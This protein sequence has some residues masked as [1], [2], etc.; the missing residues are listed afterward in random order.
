MKRWLFIAMPLLATACTSS[1]VESGLLV[2]L[3]FDPGLA[4]KCVQ[5][6]ARVG[7]TERRSGAIELTGFTTAPV[8]VARGDFPDVVTLQ[9]L[10]FSDPGCRTLTTPAE[11][12]LPAEGRFVKNVVATPVAL[13]VRREVGSGEVCTN[14]LDDDGDQQIDCADDDCNRKP[15][16]LGNACVVDQLCNN[17]A[18]GGGTLKM[19]VS[20]PSACF[21]PSGNCEAPAGECKYTPRALATCDDTDPCTT[22]DQC[23]LVGQ[24][25]GSPKPCN[26]PPSQCF[27]PTGTCSVDG[28]C[29]Y[30]LAEG[31]VCNDG[32]SCTI[33]DR[34]AADAGCSG[35]Q[36]V[37]G[38]RECAV[39]ASGCDGDG[40]CRYAPTDAGLACTGGVCN[41]GGNCIESFPYV[42]SN[43]TE[44]QIP[45]LP[46]GPTELSC[47]QTIIDTSTFPPTVTNWCGASAPDFGSAVINQADEQPLML[48]S[49]RSL[50]VFGGSSLTLKGTRNPVLVVT[51]DAQLLGSV[52]TESGSRSCATGGGKSGAAELS[53]G[54]GGGGGFGTVG[55]AGGKGIT[56]AAGGEGGGVNGEPT[57]VPLRGGCPGGRGGDN[58]TASALGGGS[59]QI[60]VGGTLTVSGTVNAPGKGGAG[61]NGVTLGPAVAGNG[62]GSGGAVL[63]EAESIVFNNAARLTANGGGGGQAGDIAGGNG[64]SG[65]SGTTSLLV[66]RGGTTGGAGGPGGDGAVRSVAA[67]AGSDSGAGGGG[68]GVIRVNTLTGCTVDPS[69]ILSPAPTSRQA[70]SGC[71]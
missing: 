46:A 34:C 51:G 12:S 18:C 5:L 16:S 53:N 66:A 59:L 27:G 63:L 38:T 1:D 4:S 35:V 41:G 57:L 32:Q 9:A 71:L 68:V 48:L 13:R 40:G 2:T 61:G 65:Q 29:Q 30:A 58:S 14:G 62:G 26:T 70:G 44:A 11:T 21:T 39:F 50:K 15:C 36:V 64:Q 67:N 20:P 23:D 19:C 25:H 60:T 43:F 55:A 33:N 31:S 10:G 24:C 3:E 8:A 37:C 28:G 52:T 54:G 22:S 45:N 6:V 17:G 69:A 7:A 42:P 56:N 49:F 47:G